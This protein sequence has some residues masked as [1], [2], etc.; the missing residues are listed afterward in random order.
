MC[1]SQAGTRTPWHASAS[2][3]AHHLALCDFCPRDMFLILPLSAAVPVTPQKADHRRAKL[4]STP[5]AHQGTLTACLA[6]CSEPAQQVQRCWLQA[7]TH[8]GH[9]LQE[10]PHRHTHIHTFTFWNQN[11]LEGSVLVSP[12]A[13]ETSGR[14]A[15]LCA[16]S[17]EPALRGAGRGSAGV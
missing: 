14:T 12:L 15:A 9:S 16:G 6:V 3:L 11:Y 8:Q 1:R 4:L 5:K 10:K 17:S 13:S 7:L 2:R